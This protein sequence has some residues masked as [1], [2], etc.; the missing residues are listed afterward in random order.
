MNSTEQSRR[1]LEQKLIS[2]KVAATVLGGIHVRTVDKLVKDGRLASVKLRRRHMIT[3][4]S[5][6]D[7]AAVK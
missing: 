7:L 5:A 3:R 6:E 1:P 4:E 2:R